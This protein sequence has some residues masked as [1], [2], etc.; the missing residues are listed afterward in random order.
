M[1]EANLITLSRYIRH[2]M[3]TGPVL[4]RQ[5]TLQLV[6]PK[7]IPRTAI[8]IGTLL[9]LRLPGSAYAAG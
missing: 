4:S 8:F 3:M 9:S 6:F 5:T 2:R 7:S 1:P